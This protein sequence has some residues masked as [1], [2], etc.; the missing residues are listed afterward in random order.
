MSRKFWASPSTYKTTVYLLIPVSTYVLNL[1]KFC[2]LFKKKSQQDILQEITKISYICIQIMFH[3]LDYLWDFALGTFT[4]PFIVKITKK[5]VDK[6]NIK[7]QKKLYQ[8]SMY[9]VWKVSMYVT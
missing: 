2:L 9:E 7:S 1:K 8:N 5:C 6:E 4:F 3:L